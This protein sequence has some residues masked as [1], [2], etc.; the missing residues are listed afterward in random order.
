MSCQMCDPVGVQGRGCIFCRS[1][2]SSVSG[3]SNTANTVSVPTKTDAAP[4]A[5]SVSTESRRTGIAPDEY[6]SILADLGFMLSG[7]E[8]LVDVTPLLKIAVMAIELELADRLLAGW[9]PLLD[10][11]GTTH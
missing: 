5:A 3:E 8:E 11:G 7:D 10:V 2:N 6:V 1:G 9:D 4:I